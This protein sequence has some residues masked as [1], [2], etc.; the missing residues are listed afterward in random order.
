MRAREPGAPRREGRLTASR[1]IKPGKVQHSYEGLQ[2]VERTGPL[3]F[4]G[5]Q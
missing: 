4:P 5:Q 2:V 3:T 1:V